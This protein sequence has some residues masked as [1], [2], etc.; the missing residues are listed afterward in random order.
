[1]SSLHPHHTTPL[2]VIVGETASGKTA[3]ALE[4][5][6]QCN[7][8][9]ICADSRTVYKGMDIGTAKPTKDEQAKIPH[10]LLDVVEPDTRFTVVDFK[11]LANEAIEDISNRG[12][13]PI[14]VG[15]T[16]LYIDSVIFNFAFTS[17]EEAALRD[18]VNP[19]HLLHPNQ[20]ARS[21]LRSNTLVIGLA[22]EREKLKQRIA[23]R[24]DAM[25]E[26]GL[27]DEVR[28][29][30]ERYG[31]EI[32]ALQAPAYKAFREYLDGRLKLDEAKALF[33]QGDLRLAKRQRTWFKRNNS[34]HWVNDR[35][36]A[37]DLAT[38][39]LRK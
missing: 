16:G 37:V 24:I 39:L 15:G 4:L 28:G 13:L 30:G 27:I 18:P 7:G 11:R 21:D 33:A 3:L 23:K 26:Q 34:I 25:L 9:I 29:L 10:H 20:S 12:R 22:V 35:S 38:T 31:W 2:I 6:E 8:E 19:R 5:A 32:A 14:M 1:M 36:K 17:P